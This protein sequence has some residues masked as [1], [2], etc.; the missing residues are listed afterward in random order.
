[1]NKTFLLLTTAIV[2]A[3]FA[4]G[5]F[6]A[7]HKSSTAVVT[8]HASR[9]FSTPSKSPSTVLSTS[10]GVGTASGSGFTT[11][12]SQSI[13]AKKAGTL[14][15]SAMI[16]ACG[17]SGEFAQTQIATVTLVD[18]TYVDFGPFAGSTQP[19]DVCDIINW[20]GIYP[21]S[22]G[23]HAVTFAAYHGSTVYLARN[24]ERTDLIK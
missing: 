11:V 9:N 22:A 21:A 14:A 16:Q 8:K 13:T 20:Q 17:F 3:G 23:T 7:A 15:I 10:S 24:T 18:G 12:A 6:A 4:T 5:G 2:S 1:M 19:S